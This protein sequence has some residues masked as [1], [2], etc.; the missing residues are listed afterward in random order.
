MEKENT[1]LVKELNL[2]VFGKMITK[3]K[4]SSYYSTVM[5]SMVVSKIIN[6]F[7]V[8]TNIE[9]VMSMKELGKMM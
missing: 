9:M 3:Y 7:R 2:Q 5:S 6:D 4:E 8:F 1:I